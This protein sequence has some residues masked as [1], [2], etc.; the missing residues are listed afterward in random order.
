MLKL[1]YESYDRYMLKKVIVVLVL[2]VT[3]FSA[4]YV[5][6]A[7]DAFPDPKKYEEKGNDKIANTSDSLFGAVIDVIQTV[8]VG[9][10]VIMLIVHA[11]RYM[12]AAPEGK[13]ELK[14]EL[15]LYTIG[16]V[17]I[18]SAASLVEFIQN[19]VRKGLE[20]A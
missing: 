13:A 16:A 19:F 17:I 3:I 10:A 8:C 18:F 1:F 7:E 15:T 11:I 12:I 2:I 5:S 20:E 6:R 4:V 9:M 14:K